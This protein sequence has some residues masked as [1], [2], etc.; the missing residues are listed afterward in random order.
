MVETP[1]H[2]RFREEQRKRREEAEPSPTPTP[3]ELKKQEVKTFAQEHVKPVVETAKK[4]PLPH[5]PYAYQLLREQAKKTGETPLAIITKASGQRYQPEEVLFGVAGLVKAGESYFRPEIRTFTGSAV[6]EA[7]TPKR[8]LFGVPK[9]PVVSKPSPMQTYWKTV[10]KH[11][12]E[13]LGELLGEYLLGRY[14]FAP[15]MERGYKK[16]KGAKEFVKRKLGRETVE[17]GFKRGAFGSKGYKFETVRGKVG[18]P[19]FEDVPSFIRQE[20]M[21]DFFTQTAR[22]TG[23]PVPV[24]PKPVDFPLVSVIKH[25]PTPLGGGQVILTQV[26][27]LSKLALRGVSSMKTK[28]APFLMKAPARYVPSAVIGLAGV[29]VYKG[30]SS[31][32]FGESE[33]PLKTVTDV[34]IG[35]TGIKPTQKQKPKPSILQ[36]ATK[37]EPFR[38]AKAKER[39]KLTPATLQS[40][41]TEQVHVPMLGYVGKLK[42]SPVQEL[43]VSQTQLQQAKQVM[44]QITTVPLKTKPIQIGTTKPRRRRKKVAPSKKRKRKKKRVSPYGLELRLYPVISS[45]E[46]MERVLH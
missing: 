36:P 34:V 25:P 46:F 37:I 2:A 31:I 24:K 42:V 4:S 33:K 5:I 11:P 32:L 13:M 21:E 19:Q 29:G 16:V 23:H 35:D 10:E 27:D 30:V 3:L 22:A 1:A 12:S 18:K 39:S 43:K 15:I 40:P 6:Q 7:V 38:L 20:G 9:F 17:T 14:V 8:T 26:D 45:K 28:V 41:L 44:K